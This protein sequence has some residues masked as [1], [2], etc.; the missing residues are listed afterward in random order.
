MP[1][2][3]KKCEH[4]NYIAYLKEREREMER[5][6]FEPRLTIR[7]VFTTISEAFER[8]CADKLK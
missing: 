7:D 4:T 3:F 5:S 1:R 2:F 8:W 6:W